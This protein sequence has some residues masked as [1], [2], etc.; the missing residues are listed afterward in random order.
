MKALSGLPIPAELLASNGWVRSADGLLF[1]VPEDG[2]YGLVS[3]VI[4]AIPNTGRQRSVRIDFTRF[5][6]GSSWTCVRGIREVESQ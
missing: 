4:T 5:Q 1:W 3:P 6:Y 2:R